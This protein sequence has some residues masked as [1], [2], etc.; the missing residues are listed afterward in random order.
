MD[1]LDIWWVGVCSREARF[2][3]VGDVVTRA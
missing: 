2:A 3:N 1:G